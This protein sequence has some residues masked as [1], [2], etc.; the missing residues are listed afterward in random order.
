MME[1][2]TET[3]TTVA[4]SDLRIVCD[5][6][7]LV[8]RISI[9]SRAVSTRSSVQV[10]SG[11]RLGSSEGKLELAATDMELSLRTNLAGSVT[12][13]GAVVVPA[14]LLTDIIRLLPAGEVVLEEHDGSLSV[15]SGSALTDGHTL[16]TP[17]AF[18]HCSSPF[19][20]IGRAHV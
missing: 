15:T 5:K 9:V 19:D 12:G 13:S 4:T 2:D 10:L 3:P 18:P 7:E 20:Q 6:D 8:S 17:H 1:T 14:K 16:A 11:I